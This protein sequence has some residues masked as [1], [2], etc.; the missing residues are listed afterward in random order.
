MSEHRHTNIRR[1]VRIGVATWVVVLVGLRL[2]VL[3]PERCGDV[4]PAEVGR[5]AASAVGWL[6]RNQLPDGRW[7]YRYDATADRD[8]GGYNNSRHS[9]VTYSLYAAAGAGIPGALE[10]ADRGSAW[11]LG[12][13]VEAGGGLAV[14]NFGAEV[15]I[16]GSALW[17]IALGERRLVTGD[18]RFDEE[19]R[20]LG[21]FLESQIERNGAVSE[22]WARRG[23]RPVPGV[24]SPF[25]TGEAYFAL[26]RLE[27]LFP[28][29]GWGAAAD[30]VGRYL[31][32]ERDEVEDYFPA[33]SDHWAAY[34]LAETAH[35][36]EL[37]TEEITYAGTLATI[38]GPQIRYASQRTESWFTHRTRGRQTLG[39]GLGTLGEGSTGLWL[40]AQL[41]PGAAGLAAVAA[42]RSRCVAGLLVERQ[43]DAAELEGF[44]DPGRV[45]GA[46]FQ[47]GVTQMDDQ[48]HAL[49]ALLNTLPIL[50]A[51]T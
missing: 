45:E 46:W 36:R 25:F 42:E 3:Q 37:T 24:Y 4:G 21:R 26:A 32:T 35:W 50:E 43:S 5:A 31:A 19:L 39:A 9:G 13:L 41:D 18:G 38:F 28:A 33:V 34:G 44:G 48:Q 47:F 40:A 1:R 10:A 11:L 6:A 49:S 29:E 15:Q 7:L 51:G 23:D 16:G 17:A 12:R 27:R 8:L 30:R 2:L 22:R 14:D 20:A